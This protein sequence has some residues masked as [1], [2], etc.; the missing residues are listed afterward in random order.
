MNSRKK[1]FLRVLVRVMNRRWHV[2]W[3]ERS[4]AWEGEIFRQRGSMASSQGL[5][6]A[7]T[8]RSECSEKAFEYRTVLWAPTW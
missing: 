4:V 8:A 2:N 6:S 3:F 7:S 1:F 5:N